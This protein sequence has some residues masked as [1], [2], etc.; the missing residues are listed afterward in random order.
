MFTVLR[1]LPVL[2]VIAVAASADVDAVG[3]AVPA[4]EEAAGEDDMTTVS[5]T[6]MTMLS[7]LLTTA[8]NQPNK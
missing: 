2:L 7:R 1:L 3:A 6:G 5:S 4:E 8:N